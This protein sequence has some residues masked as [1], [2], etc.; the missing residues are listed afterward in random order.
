MGGSKK[1][2]TTQSQTNPWA[3]A[4]PVL[5]DILGKTRDLGDNTANF[6]P[7]FSADTR[8]AISS[9][10]DVAKQGSAATAALGNVVGGSGVGYGTGLD[11]LMATARG[12]NIGGNPA[13]ESALDTAARKTANLTA[14]QFSGAGRF[15]SGQ[16]AGTMAD[17]IDQQEMAARSQQYNTERAAQMNAAGLLSQ[18][19]F[20]GAGM[21]GALDQ[22]RL[23]PSAIQ[24][25]AGAAQDQIDNAQ[26]VAPMQAV[27]WMK[28]RAAPIASLGGQSSGTSTT[29]QQPSTAG[30]IAGGLTAGIG[31]AT[32]NPAML[33]GG[34]GAFTG[35]SGGN[36][37]GNNSGGGTNTPWFGLNKLWPF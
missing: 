26:R 36:S 7:T 19:G 2:Q 31:L 15:G 6:M 8:G 33:M 20:Q 14:Q 17:R 3:P 37:G 28:G 32:G 24:A 21:A 35:Q 5:Q 23:W 11:T 22:S 4:Q 1:T 9:L 30:M 16:M 18:E 12:D 25:Q 13:F 34:T 27:D 10:S 29:T